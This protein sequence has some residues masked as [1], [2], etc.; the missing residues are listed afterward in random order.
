LQ[1]STQTFSTLFATRQQVYVHPNAGSKVDGQD[2]AWGA[3]Y[4]KTVV[5]GIMMAR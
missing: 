2:E 3:I 4:L 1:S 5:Q